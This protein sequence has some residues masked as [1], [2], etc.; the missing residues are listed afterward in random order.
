MN[1]QRPL[2]YDFLADV[3]TDAR[4]AFATVPI[5]PVPLHLTQCRWHLVGL[6]LDLLQADDIRTLALDPLL[7]LALTRPIPLTFQVASLMAGMGS[8][9]FPATITINAGGR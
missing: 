4:V 9:A 8:L 1:E 2:G 6:G 7:D 5:A 3:K